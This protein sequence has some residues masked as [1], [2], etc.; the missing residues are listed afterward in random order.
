MWSEHHSGKRN[1]QYNLW[2]VL[3]FQAWLEVN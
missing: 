2:S 3:M 1:W